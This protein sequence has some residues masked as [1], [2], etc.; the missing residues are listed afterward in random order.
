MA[1]VKKRMSSTLRVD[2]IVIYHPFPGTKRKP[3]Y[4][5]VPF[6]F[7]FSLITID[8]QGITTHYK[9]SEWDFYHDSLFRMSQVLKHIK[10]K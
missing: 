8:M 2:S 6:S 9:E 7:F 1:E 3:F 4:K 5:L 10:E